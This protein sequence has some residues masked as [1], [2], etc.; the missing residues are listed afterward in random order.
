MLLEEKT[1]IKASKK[2]IDHLRSIGY[3][4]ELKDNIEIFTKDINPG[5]HIL[6]KVKCD[7]CGKEKEI[8]FQKYIKNIKNGQFY[9]CSSKC[10]QDKVKHTSL[11]KYGSEYYT[12]TK[13]YKED[14]RKTSINKYGC[15][16][17]T[18][19]EEI[20]N[21]VK[22]T[23]IEKY[24]EDNPF[25]SYDV[26][27]KIKKTNIE[28]YGEDNPSKSDIIKNKISTNLKK[29]N[30]IKNLEMYKK[31]NVQ[32]IDYEKKEI[33]FKCD[34][35]KEHYFVISP[36][37]FQNRKFCKTVLCTICNPISSSKSGSELQLFNFIEKEYKKEILRN[38]RIIDDREI[39]IYLPDLKIGFEFNGLYWH[40][41]INKEYDY[42]LKKTE[43]SEKKGIHLIHIYEDYWLYKQDIVKS[44][45][46]NL[47]GKSNRIFARKCE[48]KEIYDNKL[49]REFL[50]QN[51][52]QGFIGSKIK[53]G[54]FYND[55][56]VSLMTFG[57]LRKAMGQK[58]KENTYEM[59]RFCNK[60]NTS[61]VGGAS[62]LFEYFIDKH[63][64]IE[65]TSY[66]DR[67]WS[68]GDLYEKLGFE[69][70]HKTQPNYYYIIDGLRKHRFNYRKNKLIK[71]GADSN[72]TEHE[73]MLEKGIFRIYDSGSLKYKKSYI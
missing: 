24:G 64:P 5:S 31:Y 8:L 58:S 3:E 55:E 35:N 51:H 17:F 16:H 69:M 70:V 23:N 34:N 37:L 44:R 36:F 66:A 47:L 14:V 15:D 56:L 73:I 25:K 48:I 20:K 46:L 33:V 42:H 21:K 72:K 57:N 54:L 11:N 4:C 19:N 67:S 71:E 12:Q 53:I 32:S 9:A 38:K 41:E 18:Q 60:L 68:S 40:N 2:N 30:K 7:I 1:K 28:K 50:E 43:L 63:E 61:I 6:V 65:I 62:R 27:E 10:A 29:W 59:L 22:K 39:D 26:K 52:L 49:V 13:E 45:I